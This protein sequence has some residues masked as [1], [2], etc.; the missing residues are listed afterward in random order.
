MPYKNR[1]RFQE[2]ESAHSRIDYARYAWLQRVKHHTYRQIAR[3]ERI[4]QK[5]IAK[6]VKIWKQSPEDMKTMFKQYFNKGFLTAKQ[7]QQYT[8][9]TPTH[10]IYRLEPGS[11]KYTG[12]P[13]D[14]YFVGDFR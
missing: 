7:W 10:D 14:F 9:M 2:T 6:S 1:G 8:G 13:L 11:G 4:S 3:D 5:T 12:T